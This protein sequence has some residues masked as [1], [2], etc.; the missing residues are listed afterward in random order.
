VERTGIMV[1]SWNSRARSGHNY[2]TAGR[3]QLRCGV[4]N[5]ALWFLQVAPRFTGNCAGLVKIVTCATK[6][7]WHCM[8]HYEIQDAEL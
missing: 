7:I 8:Q 3:Q 2:A 5:V 1:E 6:I 4:F